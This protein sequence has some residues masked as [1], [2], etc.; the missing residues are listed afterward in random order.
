MLDVAGLDE[1]AVTH[2]GRGNRV[3]IA[4]TDAGTVVVRRCN[5]DAAVWRHPLLSAVAA[6]FPVPTPLPLFAGSSVLNTRSGCWEVVSML[7]G[8]DVGF[9]E[10]P[11]MH[12]I[13]AF[14]A[15]FH[16]VSAGGTPAPGPRP[17]GLPLCH[18]PQLV[19]WDGAHRTMGSPDGVAVLD[20][21]VG[22]FA[23]DLDFVGYADLPTCLVHGDPTTFNVLADG[24]PPRPS[25]MIDFELA[26]VEAPVADIAFCLWRSG[27]P[28]QQSR[29][30]DLV[31]VRDFVAGYQSVRSLTD[32]ELAAIAVCL[33]GRGLQM[34]AKR[35]QRSIPDDG[36]LAELLW[37]EA[38][39]H[40]LTDAASGRP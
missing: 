28:A 21:L 20:R 9:D 18:L 40:E 17:G 3:W 24:D 38:H 34:L 26:D 23:A 22:R 15:A 30:L 25:G 12:E 10:Q 5:R 35:T 14:L 7:P 19:D 6:S 8:R 13:G 31:K 36:P 29:V 27:R 1:T 32:Q 37:L 33:R 39:Q 11:S 2:V 4:S 16:Y